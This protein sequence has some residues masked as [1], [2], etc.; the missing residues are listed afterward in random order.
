MQ[1]SGGENWHSLPAED[2]IR[3]FGTDARK[4]LDQFEVENRRERFGAN[5]LT[6]RKGKGPVVRFLM[7]VHQPLIYIL[8]A[9]AIIT[10]VLGEWVDSSVI[11]GIVIIN[12]IIGFVQ[13]SKALTAIAAL[14]RALTSEATVVRAGVKARLLSSELVPGDIVYLQSGDK[15][16]ADMRL[17][18]SKDLQID[19]S[20]LTGESVPAMKG[21]ETLKSDAMLADRR[22]IAFTST[23][24]TYGTGEGVVVATGDNTE[25]GRVS[26][27]IATA[28]ALATPL[29]RKIER[30]SKWL[31]IA[32]MVLAGVTLG[33]GVLRGHT[34]FDTF[35]AAVALA[36]G[37]IPEGLPAAVTIILAIGVGRM[38]KRR[39]IIRRL[40]A[41]ETLGSTTVVCSD[42]T[43]TLT[44]NQMTVKEIF[45]G[46][47]RYELSGAG[48]APSGGIARGG[49]DVSAADE[50]ALA[51][52]LRAGL[53][54]NDSTLAE[55]DGE[56]K[57]HGDPTEGALIASAIK[58]GLTAGDEERVLP[59]VD[60]IPF[61]SQ[62][63][64]MATMHDPGAG[65]RRV[66]YLKGSMESLLPRCNARLEG[67][68]TVGEFD[69][70]EVKAMVEE[71]A[72]R[73]LRI[74][75][76]ARKELSPIAETLKESDVRE[77]LT[78]LGF[79]AM[80]DPPRP[81]AVRAIE[82]CRSAGIRV[83][84]ITGDHAITATA[85]AREL[86][87]AHDGKAL[88]SADLVG[89]SDEEFTEAAL[90]TDV[91][92]RMSPE[93]KF[94]LV[95]ALQARGHVVAMTG[96]GVNDA[97]SLRR[98]DIG[99]AMGRGGTEVA[100]E[101]SDMVLTDDNFATIEAAVEEGRG[102]FDNL[103]KFI[104]WTVPANLGEGLVLMLAI[105]L[106]VALPITPVQILWINMTTAGCLGLMLAFEPME[107]DIMER[108]PRNPK[109]P[110]LSVSVIVRIT[111]VS[112]LLCIGSFVL[113]EWAR[114][115]GLSQEQARTI[116][117]NVFVVGEL[118]YLLSCRSLTRSMFAVGMFS[119]P[120]IWVGVAISIALQIAFTYAPIMN[121]L[122]HTA[123]F[124]IE[125]WIKI[126][127]VGSLI[128][129]AVAIDKQI[130]KAISKN[131]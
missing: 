46:G 107:G 90:T 118:F 109:L 117:V 56:W 80:I 18:R 28:E 22:N 34:W 39:A 121:R 104:V 98:A 70:G 24:V 113:Y 54:C 88:T 106:G 123:A 92:A 53:I 82:A 50:I 41:V 114:A 86:G 52:C 120:W 25:I 130:V 111:V 125:E 26:E 43:G 59:R 74:L 119:N 126:V 38:A 108:V 97:P 44:K 131:R 10:A 17:I 15:V 9:S 35:M 73:G 45:A 48:Y 124:P 21:R 99:I 89:L 85:I 64:F 23:L 2:A 94:R 5:V 127:A 11:W 68:G 84:M 112:F 6:E 20:A 30:F 16:P 19:E 7:Q 58:G 67:D 96:D 47:A 66:V 102:V 32:I 115:G 78:F 77:G 110:L 31:L 72:S 29:T 87:I 116:A 63:H 71:A 75:V 36:V 33:I 49:E 27:M 76:F 37:A 13:E 101:A 79:Q 55:E 4:G 1:V 60:A 81:E 69:A 83:K 129:V 14:K 42:K 105:F 3:F 122:F 91:F 95:E 93:Q 100:R 61:E 103:L 62:H 128:S 40:P 51:Q 57:V 65:K 8:I 12:A